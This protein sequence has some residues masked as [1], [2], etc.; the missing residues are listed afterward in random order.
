MTPQPEPQ[1]QSAPKSSLDLWRET[2]SAALLDTFTKARTAA[3]WRET[4][5]RQGRKAY[6]LPTGQVV[7]KDGEGR[8]NVTVYYAGYVSVFNTGERHGAGFGTTTSIREGKEWA[9]GDALSD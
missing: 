1:N 7:C 6:C 3:E 2:D 5:D 9:V 8:R 4:T